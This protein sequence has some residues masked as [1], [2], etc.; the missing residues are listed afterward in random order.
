[1][2]F[3][4]SSYHNLTDTN[5]FKHITHKLNKS[6]Y[7]YHRITPGLIQRININT[8]LYLIFKLGT[9]TVHVML[10]IF[11]FLET[12]GFYVLLQRYWNP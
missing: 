7:Y 8:K 3:N 11:C 4:H 10:N 1:M 12:H 5:V 2:H 9:L 6:I